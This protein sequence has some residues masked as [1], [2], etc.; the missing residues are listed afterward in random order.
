MD[1]SGISRQVDG[2]LGVHEDAQSFLV[3][4]NEDAEDW[5]VRFEKA[6]DVRKGA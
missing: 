4:I 6:P 5:L 1:D 2:T 3:V